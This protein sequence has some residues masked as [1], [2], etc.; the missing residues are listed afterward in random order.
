MYGKEAKPC[1]CYFDNHY[2]KAPRPEE[3]K[4]QM[5]FF[6]HFLFAYRLNI[7]NTILI[8][9]CSNMSG[10]VS[11]SCQDC[12][13]GSDDVDDGDDVGLGRV[14]GARLLRQ[15]GPQALHVHR[16]AEVLLLRLVELTHT[17]LTEVTRMAGRK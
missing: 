2:V 7:L 1:I 9:F 11:K 14:D 6:N 8:L 3:R 4:P 15:K 17:N 12:T 16:W 5:L 10:Y 13:Y